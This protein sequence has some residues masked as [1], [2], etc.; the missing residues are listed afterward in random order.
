MRVADSL[1]FPGSVDLSV[2]LLIFLLQK[3]FAEGQTH[4]IVI[5]QVPIY[6]KQIIIITA[7]IAI[8]ARLRNPHFD[9]GG[10]F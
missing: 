6:H 7:L 4:E 2:E 3:G 5:F 10:M 1:E 8:V 9:L